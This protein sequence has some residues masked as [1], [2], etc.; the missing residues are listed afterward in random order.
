MTRRYLTISIAALAVITVLA[1]NA[2]IVLLE[3]I[4]P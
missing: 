1:V 4:V 2:F 3:W